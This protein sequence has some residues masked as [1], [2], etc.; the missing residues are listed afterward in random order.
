M[1]YITST[2][3]HC[4]QFST[5]M[6][7]SRVEIM[8]YDM[9]VNNSVNKTHTQIMHE[10][11]HWSQHTQIMLT[12][13][14]ARIF[15]YLNQCTYNIS[16]M[17]CCNN[18]LNRPPV[19]DAP[20]CDSQLY[21]SGTL[22]ALYTD[23]VWCGNDADSIQFAKS[24]RKSQTTI[25]NASSFLLSRSDMALCSEY[26]WMQTLNWQDLGRIFAGMNGNWMNPESLYNRFLLS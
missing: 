14:F 26:C 13:L 17:D 1:T 20:I 11:S 22:C 15:P 3:L 6:V 4:N 19:G 7:K 18:N 24:V 16:H 21:A 2:A 23:P 8:T 9:L 12:I 5:T 10:E 25:Q